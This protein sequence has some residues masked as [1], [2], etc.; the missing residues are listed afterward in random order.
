MD[1]GRRTLWSHLSKLTCIPIVGEDTDTVSQCNY[2]SLVLVIQLAVLKP[3]S[4]QTMLCVAHI[5]FKRKKEVITP[6][7]CKVEGITIKSEFLTITEPQSL[8]ATTGTQQLISL[9]G[10]FALHFTLILIIPYSISTA[11][12]T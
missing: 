10:A 7:A 9:Y 4:T 2:L 8:M 3:P 5:L 6:H 1:F 11:H 12:I